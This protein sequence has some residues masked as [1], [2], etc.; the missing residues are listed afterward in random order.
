MPVRQ[1]IEGGLVPVKVYTTDIEDQAME[2]LRKLSL[3]PFIHSHVAAMP[4]AHLGR[5]STIGSVIPTSGAIIPAA[6]GVDLGCGMAAVR[7]DMSSHD[8]PENLRSIRRAIEKAVPH[9]RTAHGGRNDRGSWGQTPKEVLKHWRKIDIETQL[10]HVLARHKKLI[11]PKTNTH[12]HLGT[13][14]TGNH[15]IELCLDEEDRVWVMLHSGS[16]GVGNRIGSYFIACA[17]HEMDRRGI[18]VPDEDLSYLPEDSELYDDYVD[19]LNWAQDYAAWNRRVM[20][21]ATLSAIQKVLKRKAFVT[22]KAIQCH[23][24][25]VAKETHFGQEVLVTRKGAIRAGAGELGIIPGSMGAQSYIVRG[26]GNPDSFCSCSHGAGRAMS[27]NAARRRF[28]TADLETQTEG[29]E[30]RKDD[31]VLDEI[32]GAYKDIDTVMANQADL[33]EVVH[34]LRQIVNVKG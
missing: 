1:T 29:I 7:L 13:L 11:G 23:H 2:Q 17:K 25:Y 6:V 19:A 8:L 32:P 10:G 33:V 22:E 20:L 18:R 16:R 14:G 12:R 21:E 15:F 27:R 9:G 31:G 4:D 24:N 3:M 28:T 30:C 26:K 34:T 5:G